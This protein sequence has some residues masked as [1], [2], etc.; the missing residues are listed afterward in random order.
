MKLRSKIVLCV[1]MA[2]LAAVSLAM[3]LANLGVLST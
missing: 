1:L 3:V 2:A